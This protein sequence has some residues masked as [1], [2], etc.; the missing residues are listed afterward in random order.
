MQKNILVF[1]HRPKVAGAI[2]YILNDNKYVPLIY[3]KHI[4]HP[5]LKNTSLN[6][7]IFDIDYPGLD[8]K[9]I[10]ETG[11][12]NLEKCIP[13][14]LIVSESTAHRK[15]V[16]EYEKGVEDFIVYPFSHSQLLKRI[17]VALCRFQNKK[18]K[19]NIIKKGPFVVNKHSCEVFVE[20]KFI[21][22]TKK[23]FEL[24][25]ILIEKTGRVLSKDYL[26]NTLWVHNEDVCM[27]IIDVLIYR[28]RRKI[29]C[30]TN[31]YI[32]TYYGMGYSFIG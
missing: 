4:N 18:K 23:E 26:I 19:G 13:V 24:F 1:E 31:K 20:N 25:C 22:L 17:E 9:E 5:D 30:N 15:I 2:E 16:A 11:G 21:K 6:A 10:G 8:I 14:I 32:K 29:G 28:L 7:I 3:D 27:R 12:I